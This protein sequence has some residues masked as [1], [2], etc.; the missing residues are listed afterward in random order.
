MKWLARA[1]N[2]LR[3]LSGTRG[4]Y[5][6][7]GYFAPKYVPERDGEKYLQHLYDSQYVMDDP[8]V[9]EDHKNELMHRIQRGQD[10]NLLEQQEDL[11]N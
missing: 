2:H 1:N 9:S 8:K 11:Q 6:K 7:L 4:I 3:A 10:E 5:N